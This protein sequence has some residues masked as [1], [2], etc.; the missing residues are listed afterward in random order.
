VGKKGGESPAYDEWTK[1]DLQERARELG[2]EGRSS[3]S[4]SQL[5]DALRNHG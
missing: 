1:D 5:V 2:V 3:M 4:K